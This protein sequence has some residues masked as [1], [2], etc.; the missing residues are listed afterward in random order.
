MKFACWR[1][2]LLFAASVCKLSAAQPSLE[3]QVKAAFLL[4]FVR[5][6]EWPP[7]TL[8][9]D[10]PFN[11]CIVGG[12]PFGPAI[13]Q[14]VEGESV[15]GHKLTV[16]RLREGQQASCQV[17]YMAGGQAGNTAA[18]GVL[19]VGE[20]DEFIRHGGIIAFVID[21]RRV[22]FDIN[23][24]AATSAGLKLSSKLLAVA[25]SIER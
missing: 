16:T 23:L 9:T 18:P 25:R 7:G 6:V 12:D 17:L 21:N 14:I 15:S 22:R 4:N 20:S 3:Y 24:K 10:A 11:V 19:T 1:A 2:A 5:F 13:D 8:G